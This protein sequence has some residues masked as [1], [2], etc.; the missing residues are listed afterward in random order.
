MNTDSTQ[1]EPS[2][3]DLW[4]GNASI[5]CSVEDLQYL[6]ADQNQNYDSVNKLLI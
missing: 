3:T 6:V 2:L 1:W 5:H 4:R